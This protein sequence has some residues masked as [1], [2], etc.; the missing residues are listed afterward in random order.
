MTNIDRRISKNKKSHLSSFFYNFLNTKATRPLLFRIL[1]IS[2]MWDVLLFTVTMRARSCFWTSF[3]ATYSII[4][5]KESKPF[6]PKITSPT[7]FCI[8]RKIKTI[9][10]VCYSPRMTTSSA[11]SRESWNTTSTPC[12]LMI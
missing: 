6:Q 7:S 11:N 5:L 9:S 12:W 4:F 3:A 1:L 2:Q 10:P 8:F